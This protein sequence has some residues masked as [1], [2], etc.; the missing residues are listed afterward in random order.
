[1]A[2]ASASFMD[3]LQ[4]WMGLHVMPV[5]DKMNN[6]AHL[7]AIRNAMTLLIPLTIVGGFAVLLAQP[8]ITEGSTNPILLAWQSMA[9]SLGNYLWI[10]YFLTMGALSLYTVAG[11]A[12][13]LAEN[14]GLNS[15]VNAITALATFLIVSDAYDG[16]T[17]TLV[18]GQFGAGYMFSAIIVAFIVVEINRFFIERDIK[19]K[20]PETVPPNVT[21]PFEVLF[22]FIT[23]VVLMSAVNYACHAATGAGFTSLVFT[24]LQPL[25]SATGS[26]PSVM[27]INFLISFFWF[28]GIHGDNM[29]AAVTTP[30]TT[31]AIAANAEAY[32]AG[33]AI[34]Y[35]F[36]GAASTVFGQWC[37]FLSLQFVMLFVCKSSRLKSLVKVSLVPSMF[38]INEPGV[39]GIPTVLNIFVF[40]PQVICCMLNYLV[41]ALAANAGLVGKFVIAAPWTTPG[42]IN[43][44]LATGFDFRAVVLWFVLFAVNFVLAVPF[45]KAYDKQLLAEEAA[46]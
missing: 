40:I 23:N 8:P 20:M 7:K 33:E 15:F 31:A 5:A 18:L 21:A 37:F 27:V 41:Y 25:M 32:A 24:I 39:F 3:K 38:N 11:V 35:T 13:F 17:G 42:P 44:L 26:I 30:I 2:E 22:P 16:E 9:L 34:P 36:A 4:E 14:Y 12:Y 45:L 28:F 46:E 19:I 29:V 1:M 43:A 6:Q 10:P